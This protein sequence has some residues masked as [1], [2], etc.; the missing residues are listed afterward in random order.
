MINQCL[1][2]HSDH[3]SFVTHSMGGIVLREYLKDHKLHQLSRIIMLGPPNHGSQTV[4]HE[5]T[6]SCRWFS[7]KLF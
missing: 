4:P 5:F 3:I 6:V 2:N 1:I 7:G